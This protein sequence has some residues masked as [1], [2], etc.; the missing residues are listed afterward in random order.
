[1]HWMGA[2]AGGPQSAFVL[3]HYLRNMAFSLMSNLSL[4]SR[5]R[6]VPIFFGMLLASALAAAVKLKSAQVMA[7]LG[8][9][10]YCISHYGKILARRRLVKAI[11]RRSD[12]EIF[13]KIM[14][15][16]RLD[17]FLKT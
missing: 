11:R 7:H 16:P 3:R 15:T 2:T 5:L 9:I 14:R 13:A 8:A 4:C 10:S 6:I 1:Q 17:Y 12:R